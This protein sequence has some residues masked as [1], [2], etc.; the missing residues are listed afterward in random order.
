MLSKEDRK[1]LLKIACES[2]SNYFSK[3]KVSFDL[4]I[5]Q[6]ALRKPSG[7][8]VS[9]HKG[10]ELR[11]CIGYIEPVE[12][13]WKA[14]RDMAI[15]AAFRDPRFEP[16]SED[17]LPLLEIE[18]SVLSPLVKIKTIDEIVVPKHGLYIVKGFY[19]GL[20][21][22]Q[23]AAKYHW[24]KKTFLEETAAKAG[25][26]PNAWKDKETEIYIFE[27]EVFSTKSEKEKI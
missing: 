27:A 26:P 15:S 22:P 10:G 2:I 7:V 19:S 4:P 3:G 17:E 24:D 11:G 21:L 14:V 16:L 9:I 1:V 13:L 20:L 12:A 23:V 5:E 18:I 8:F 25:L 6:P